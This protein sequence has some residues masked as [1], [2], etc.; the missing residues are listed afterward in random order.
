MTLV[1]A[2]IQ[3][4]ISEVIREIL[5]GW[6]T[7]SARQGGDKARLGHYTRARHGVRV[8]AVRAGGLG[9]LRG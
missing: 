9:V 1:A 5:R 2:F 6:F 4:W 3:S 8:C 7:P